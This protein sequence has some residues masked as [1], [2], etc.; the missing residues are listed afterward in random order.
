MGEL[1][2]VNYLALPDHNNAPSGSAQLTQCAL[3]PLPSCLE[4]GCPEVAVCFC[5]ICESAATVPMPKASVDKDD[6]IVFGQ[7]DVGVAWQVPPMQSESIAHA[8]QH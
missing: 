8:V 4:L 1:I 5:G 2:D 3:V 7:H 6:C